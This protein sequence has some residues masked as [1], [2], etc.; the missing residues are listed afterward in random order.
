MEVGFALEAK[1]SLMTGD[2]KNGLANIKFL[3]D[4]E[5]VRGYECAFAV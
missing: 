1:A 5:R 4:T 2:G 3:C